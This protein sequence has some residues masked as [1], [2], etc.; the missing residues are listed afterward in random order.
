MNELEQRD[1]GRDII[2][3]LVSLVFLFLA[4]IWFKLGFYLLH[5][6]DSRFPLWIAQLTYWKTMLIVFSVR[7]LI[8]ITAGIKV[9]TNK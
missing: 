1:L 3:I 4:P 6:L 7:V 9:D 2:I 5:V 8:G